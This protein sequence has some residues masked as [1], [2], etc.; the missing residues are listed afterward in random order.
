MN[1]N[2]TS[3]N[4][5][6]DD[7]YGYDNWF[8]KRSNS[9]LPYG[10]VPPSRDFD[11]GRNS[12]DFSPRPPSST[13]HSNSA[14]VK[15]KFPK[16]G[17]TR[18]YNI[19]RPPLLVE[20][21]DFISSELKEL[22]REMNVGNAQPETDDWLSMR[23]LKIYK[24]AFQRFIDEFTIYKPILTSI[25]HEYETAFDNFSSK[26]R[27]HMSAKTEFV[28]FEREHI[29]KMSQKDEQ[30]LAVVTELEEKM[31]TTEKKL[32]DKEKELRIANAQVDILKLAAAK[33]EDIAEDVK[34]SCITLTN[35][36]KR[37]EAEKKELVEVDSEKQ[38]EILSL[39]IAFHKASA[40]L[41]RLRLQV[42]DMEANQSTL[43]SHDMLEKHVLKIQELRGQ[44]IAKDSE[45]RNLIQRYAL[46][47][48]AVEASCKDD[49]AQLSLRRGSSY[50]DTDRFNWSEKDVYKKVQEEYESK[51]LDP[52]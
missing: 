28:T 9:N 49:K 15:N 36:L 33:A 17:T 42:H 34:R 31:R 11:S 12:N 26:A 7:L 47:K 16:F 10:S 2:N 23:R 5:N 40:E 21:E 8:M 14:S 20:L 39:K 13:K 3:N 19:A 24:D 45:H 52:R 35:A 41:E 50:F 4:D 1:H 32:E 25:K 46:L 27:K 51:A 38:N 18:Q 29:Q 6:N 30:H 43:V 22:K 48:N 37:N 44:V